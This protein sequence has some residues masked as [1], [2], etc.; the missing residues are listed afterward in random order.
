MDL[1]HMN[2][3]NQNKPGSPETKLTEEEKA[4]LICLA[5]FP[6]RQSAHQAGTV[7]LTQ[8]HWYVLFPSKDQWGL[9]VRSAIAE[10]AT[11]LVEK[12]R[13]E[14][15]AVPLPAPDVTAPPPIAVAPWHLIPAPLLLMIIFGLSTSEKGA[16]LVDSGRFDSLRIL[17]NGEWWRLASPLFLHADAPH[18][19]GNVL[20]G[21][22]FG[23]LLASRIGAAKTYLIALLSGIAG[24]SLNLW[25]FRNTPHLSI[26]ASTAVFGLLGAL[27]GLRLRELLHGESNTPHIPVSLRHARRIRYG[28]LGIGLFILSWMGIGGALTDVSAHLYGF[29]SGLLILFLAPRNI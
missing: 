13:R 5:Y 8:K 6:S 27:I 1:N 20:G 29:I 18:L 14:I 11:K 21:L 19:L 23:G 2:R 3:S 26:G 25:T 17:N 24:N 9:Y 7:L 15:A 28:V 10:E 22:L 16:A 4:D 12:N